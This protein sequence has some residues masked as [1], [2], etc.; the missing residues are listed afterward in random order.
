MVVMSQI[1]GPP[2]QP[3]PSPSPLVPI[4]AH[5]SWWRRPALIIPLALVVTV[6]VAAALFLALRPRTIT[7]SGTVIDGRTGRPV[8]MASLHAAGRSARTNARGVFRIP[9]L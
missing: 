5:R 9:G 1:A 7:A 3:L 6:A 8:A 2:R 4:A